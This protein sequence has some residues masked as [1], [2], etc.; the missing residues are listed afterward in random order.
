MSQRD[1]EP[2]RLRYGLDVATQGEWSHPGTL[3]ELAVE[4]EKAGWDGLFLW[5]LL[6]GEAG[7]AVPVADPWV[8]LG[9]IAERTERIRLGVAVVA[10]PRRRPWIVARQIATLDHLSG[11]R[12]TFAA[13]L[14]WQAEDFAR[15][16]EDPEPRVRAQLLDE[17]LGVIAGLWRG[18]PFS[19]AGSHH[20]LTDVTLLPAPVQTPRPT[21]WLAAGWPRRAPL[22]RAARWD[23]VLLMTEHQERHGLLNP[24]DVRQV[25]DEARAIRAAAGLTGP[26]DIA[27]NVESLADPEAMRAQVRA[28]GDAGA[29]WAI[30]LTPETPQD[31][32]A[33]VRRGPPA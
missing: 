31:H 1:A 33:L 12:V 8:V 15:F 30:E 22:R 14:G 17:G 29:T 21:T 24:D 7:A 16:G 32:L 4:A 13:G 6:L 18:G 2:P 19:Y 10:L 23:G 3:V 28:F 20:R 11:G 27:V 9:A 25:R 26:F 5:D